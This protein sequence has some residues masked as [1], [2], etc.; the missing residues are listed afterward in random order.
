MPKKSQINEYS[1]LCFYVKLILDY[2]C[3]SSSQHMP[4]V[5]HVTHAI[6]T[7]CS[8]PIIL[9]QTE[10]FLICNIEFLTWKLL[11]S[12]YP[13]SLPKTHD[14]LVGSFFP[15]LIIYDF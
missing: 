1:D 11:W 5:A 15:L 2:R 8:T 13:Q 6:N 12:W 7:P 4:I 9:R 14:D 3:L 10:A